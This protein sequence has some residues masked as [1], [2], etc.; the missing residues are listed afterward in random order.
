MQG[1]NKIANNLSEHKNRQNEATSKMG[2]N[3]PW[4]GEMGSSHLL[5][6]WSGLTKDRSTGYTIIVNFSSLETQ[7]Q[8]SLTV[9]IMNILILPLKL[10]DLD[11][12][13]YPP[14][15]KPSLQL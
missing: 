9:R 11:Q 2:E 12:V 8:L 15:I 7:Q 3:K 14:V 4:R 10:Q 6:F 13:P 1:M 5:L